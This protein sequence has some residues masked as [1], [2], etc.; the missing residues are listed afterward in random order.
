MGQWRSALEGLVIEGSK[1]L[2]RL[3]GVIV[4]TSS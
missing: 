2:F 3:N 1:Y 4:S